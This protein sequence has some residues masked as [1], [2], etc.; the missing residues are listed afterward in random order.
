MSLKRIITG[1]LGRLAGAIAE[2][3]NVAEISDDLRRKGNRHLAQQ[4]YEQAAACYRHSLET[5]PS[6]VAS[7]VNLG[8]VLAELGQTDEAE[9]YLQ[10][11]V[12]IDHHQHDAY[13]L[14]GN[15]WQS[16]HSDDQAI[17]YFQHAFTSNP[18]FAEAY[19]AFT[20][21]CTRAGKPDHAIATLK[22]ATA[23]HPNRATPHRML[24]DALA[25]QGF[26]SEALSSYQAALAIDAENADTLNNLATV[27][28]QQ[29]QLEAALRHFKLAERIAPTSAAIQNN[30]GSAYRE[31]GDFNSAIRHYQNAI[32]LEPGTASARNNLANLLRDEGQHEYA[33]EHYQ[34]A[35]QADPTCAKCHANMGILFSKQKLFSRAVDAYQNAI[36]LDPTK[37]GFRMGLAHAAQNACAWDGLDVLSQTI[38]SQVLQD[39]PDNDPIAPFAFLSL[40]GTTPAE[41]LACAR[42]YAVQEFRSYAE[43]R[44][45]KRPPTPRERLR[46]GYCSADFNQHP[47]AYLMA[48]VFELHDRTQFEIH[49]YSYGIDDQSPIRKRLERAF[50]EFNDIRSYSI[51]DAAQAIRSDGIDIL[52]DLTGYTANSRT[53]IFALKPAS[54]QVNYL[55]FLG[56][57]GADFMDFI[58]A[59]DFIIPA[60]AEHH[61]SEQVVRLP[62]YQANDRQL[63]ILA[64]PERA[65]LGLPDKAFVFC[66]FN[67]TYKILPQYFQLWLQLLKNTP[68]SVL[69]LYASNDEARTNLR[70]AAKAAGISPER[71]VFAPLLP[72]QQHIARLQCADLFL[73][74]SPYNAGTTASNALWAGIPLIT[75]PGDTFSSRMAGSLLI[76]AGLPDLIARDLDAYYR[77]ALDLSHSPERMKNLRLRVLQARESSLLFDSPRFTKNLEL[78]YLE[79]YEVTKADSNNSR[80]IGDNKRHTTPST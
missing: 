13:Y 72:L 10:A 75:C 20:R 57:T 42:T 66:N 1:T 77:L 47:V 27:L 80:H 19:S 3:T 74:T 53:E 2:R 30:L 64:P 79:M 4:E 45:E 76:S 46:I 78:A 16:R 63:Q 38:R 50:D 15:L 36:R 43:R 71:L 58:L 54:V 55:G 14:L 65:E 26:L 56:T 69:W 8:F 7:L 40:P 35:L 61:Y 62:S 28:K 33:L 51:Q 68:N 17:L 39:R 12:A 52:V 32:T 48:E 29:G 34:L 18:D 31:F 73:D 21:A 49:A 6:N 5:N 44:L 67:Q 60:G 70:H 37:N 9:N 23:R 22:S 41:Q 11:A 25:D 24:A 59:D